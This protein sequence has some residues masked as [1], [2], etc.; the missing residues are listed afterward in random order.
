MVSPS[1]KG[2]YGV[3]KIEAVPAGGER[4]A[5]YSPG[6][7]AGAPSGF[8]LLDYVASRSET[9]WSTLPV[10]VPAS[11][12]PYVVGR[13]V[14][15]NLALTLALGKP[16]SSQEEAYLRS[17]E[18]GFLLHSTSLPDTATTWELASDEWFKATPEKPPGLLYLGG[19]PDLCRLF[20]TAAG[21]NEPIPAPL[22]PEAQQATFPLY[23]F[24]RGCDGTSPA[25]RLVGVRNRTKTNGEPKAMGTCEVD[26]GVEFGAVHGHSAFNAAADGGREV[27]F[28]TCIEGNGYDRQLFVRLDGSKTLEISKPFSPPAPACSEVPCLADGAATRANAEFVG[29]SEDGSR[30]FFTTTAPLGGTDGD[31]A[32]DLYMVT[33][34]CQPS[35]PDCPVAA[36]VVTSLTQVSH[37]PD[38]SAAEVQGVVKLAPDG[39]RVYF[40]ATGDLLGATQRSVLEA[41]GQAVPSVGAENLYVYDAVSGVTTFIADLCTG[42]NKSGTRQDAHCPSAAGASD[43]KLWSDLGKG[44]AQ[45]AGVDGRFLAFSSYAQMTKSDT[46]AARDV[47]RYD[48]ETGALD[49]VSLG[50]EGYKA[51]GNAG[52]FDAAIQ[53][54]LFG[55][56]GVRDQMEMSNRTISE[57]GSHVVFLSREP[58]SPAATNHLENAYVWQAPTGAG[59]GRVSMISS[60]TASEP[61]F[62]S[63]ITPQGN[64]VFFTTSQSLVAADTDQAPDLYDARVDGGFP[65]PSAATAPCSGDACQGPLT[66]PAPLLVP[67]SASQAPGDNLRAARGL[68]KG[69]KKSKAHGRKR[70][71]K[72]RAHHRSRVHAGVAGS[73]GR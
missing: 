19:S 54:G 39:R 46:D 32:T 2:G 72:R 18:E 50:E 21:I 17:T 34:G 8:E 67:E 13:D 37:A 28:T 52:G 3:L 62:E 41:E 11:S 30:A 56:R 26:F 66:N 58:L 63:V 68:P 70:P 47:Y 42:S 10:M 73:S 55:G 4:V 22:L 65:E 12:A 14:S 40:V 35:E 25:L 33:I 16:G 48:G 49:R 1:Y 20:F 15:S 71:R 43:E 31:A 27:F 23:E 38:S 59:E 69:K 61:I 64:D 44:E 7:F 5:Y 6:T 60:G 24:E 36:K 57:D 9:G 45:T 29:A 51:N 53:F